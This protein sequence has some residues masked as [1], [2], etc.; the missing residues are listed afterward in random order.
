MADSKLIE[1]FRNNEPPPA[2]PGGARRPS[3]RVD[4]QKYDAIRRRQEI[5]V[6]LL[7]RACGRDE[8]PELSFEQED[9]GL[10]MQIA[11]ERDPNGNPAIRKHA[12]RALG[13]YRN[14]EAAELLWDIASSEMEHETIRGR[15]LMALAQATP[16]VAPALVQSY[17]DNESALIRQAAVNAL[18]EVGNELSL[19]AVIELLEREEDPGIRQRA[20]IAVQSIGKRLGVRVPEVKV[21]ERPKEPRSPES[22]A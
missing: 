17:L 7:Q 5:N 11:R 19:K 21:T 1:E 13:I 18:A 12:I 9:L 6:M 14:L 22:D 3:K 16:T 8:V 4:L 20:A 2:I 10:L 15:A